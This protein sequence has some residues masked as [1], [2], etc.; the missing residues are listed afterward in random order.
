MPI[1]EIKN[2]VSHA[3]EVEFKPLKIS[4]SKRAYQL[5]NFDI[6]AIIEWLE[7]KSA[8]KDLFQTLRA[9]AFLLKNVKGLEEL[10][11][12]TVDKMAI[13]FNE[14]SVDDASCSFYLGALSDIVDE[15][16]KLNSFL[17]EAGVD[18]LEQDSSGKRKMLIDVQE[19]LTLK[20][21]SFIK[22]DKREHKSPSICAQSFSRN[23]VDKME[24]EEVNEDSDYTEDA[25]LDNGNKNDK[26]ISCEKAMNM[27]KIFVDSYNKSSSGG[28]K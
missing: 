21:S 10:F 27:L 11:D 3:I 4:I 25:I 9:I 16:E 1:K 19:Y 24:P 13:N 12:E 7:N 20:Q 15:T 18:I 22:D 26:N 5:S 2:S 28:E 8:S 17:E 6:V 14:K 23:V